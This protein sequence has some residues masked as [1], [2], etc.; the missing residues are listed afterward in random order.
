MASAS[1]FQSMEGNAPSLP[2]GGSVNAKL[3]HGNDGA[4][5]VHTQAQ[6]NP[7]SQAG[8]EK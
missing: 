5:P 6:K 4:F 1:I 2:L 3:T 7:P 8:F